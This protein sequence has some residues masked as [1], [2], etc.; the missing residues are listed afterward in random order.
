M[1]MDILEINNLGI[2][3]LNANI[4]KSMNLTVNQRVAGSSP[5]KYVLFNPT[6]NTGGRDV[7]GSTQRP[8]YIGLAHEL[9]HVQDIWRGTFDASTWYTTGGKAIPKGEIYASHVENMVR[10]ENNIPLRK[11]YTWSSSGRLL[12]NSNDSF[13]YRQNG[14]NRSGYKKIKGSG[15][16]Y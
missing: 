4:R 3:N 7:N 6:K 15:Y 14:I 1:L 9:A 11:F 13:Y 10:A 5:A 12:N 2:E 16:V 8:A